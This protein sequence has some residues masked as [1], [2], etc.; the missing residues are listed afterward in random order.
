ML[1]RNFQRGYGGFVGGAWYSEHSL[2]GNMAPS[3]CIQ[4]DNANLLSIAGDYYIC[5]HWVCSGLVIGTW[6][7]AFCRCP[8]L[9][10]SQLRVNLMWVV[11]LIFV[12]NICVCDCACGRVYLLQ[13]CFGSIVRKD[14]TNYVKLRAVMCSQLCGP[15]IHAGLAYP[16]VRKLRIWFEF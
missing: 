12:S 9:R 4:S 5:K 7:P 11:F 8:S 3:P 2:N 14:N 16:S 13:V 6:P 10:P 1:C 15:C